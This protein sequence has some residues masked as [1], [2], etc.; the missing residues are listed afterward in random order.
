VPEGDTIYRAAATLHRA[1]AGK[2]VVRFESVLPA[3]TRIHEDH[4]LTRASVDRV[5]SVGK[6]LLMH[7]SNGFVLRTHMRMNGSWHIYRPGESWRRPAR[8]CR[9]LVATAD[10]EAVGFNIPVAELIPA[11]ALPRHRELARIGPDLL[12]AGF[13]AAEALRRLRA[14]P[15]LAIADA[16]LDQR[17]LAGIG[18]VYKSEVLFSC[19]INP[20]VRVDTLDDT[21]LG[22][23]ID[24]GRRLLAANV[25]TR[26]A[27]MTTYAGFRRTTGHD[28]PGERLWVYGRA[29]LP[30]R[31]CGTAI[32]LRK[33]GS[34]ARLTY[35]CPLCQKS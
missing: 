5:T 9:V 2:P 24:T 3:L 33:Q 18:N 34:D 12:A 28:Q 13:D 4:P 15:A 16:L 11:S 21:A 32:E 29:R 7:F 8:D 35:W 26:L 1:L 17:V 22:C 25:S 19:G 31:R 10:F 14:R 30:C 20:F 27:P 23:L 6:H